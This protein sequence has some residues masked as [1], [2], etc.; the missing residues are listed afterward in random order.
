MFEDFALIGG[1]LIKYG[2]MLFFVAFS[3]A[4]L[5]SFLTKLRNE[6]GTLAKLIFVTLTPPAMAISVPYFILHKEIG[7][8]FWLNLIAGFAIYA[9]A[10]DFLERNVKVR[11]KDEDTNS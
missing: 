6:P 2:I 5:H 11:F 4:L 10:T 1:V 7:T 9:F 3:I 8:P